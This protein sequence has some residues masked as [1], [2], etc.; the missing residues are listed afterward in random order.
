MSGFIWQPPPE[1]VE[2]ANLTRLQRRLG[3]GDYHELHRISVDEP[4][5]FWP[6]LIDDLDIEFSHP[7]SSIVDVSR[8]PEWATWFNGARVDVARVC[9]HR[10]AEERPNEEALVGLYEDGTHESLSYAEASRQVTQLAESLVELGVREGD[11]VA[12]YMPMSPAV[13]VAA[14][15]CAHIGAVHV[16][17]FSGFAAPAIASRLE[18]SQAK[19]A[20]CA[21]WSLRRGERIEMSEPLAEAGPH[22]LEHVLEWRRESRSWQDVV[23]KQPGALPPL[24]VDSEA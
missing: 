3:A 16:P 17:I 23:T 22:A 5:R 14:H 15:A 13:A 4:D 1:L 6:E 10:W 20:I 11:R 21:D 12:I 18:D 7:W 19:V 8:G 2:R 9:L 24:E